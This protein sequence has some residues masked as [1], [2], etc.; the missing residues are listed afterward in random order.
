M[1]TK[2]NYMMA[3][4]KNTEAT[5]EYNEEGFHSTLVNIE[6]VYGKGD[7]PR[8]SLG[9]SIRSPRRGPG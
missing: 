3:V 5:L 8:K 9:T 7:A 4:R 6:G 1:E 2:A